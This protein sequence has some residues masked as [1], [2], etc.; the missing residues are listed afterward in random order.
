MTIS[1]FQKMIDMSKL[2]GEYNKMELEAPSDG[3]WYNINPTHS[4]GQTVAD[5][6]GK[7][8]FPIYISQ[9]SYNSVSIK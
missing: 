7:G 9:S 5:Q 1:L 3:N 8:D 2:S 6:T 4:S